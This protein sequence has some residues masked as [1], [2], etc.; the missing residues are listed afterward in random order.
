PRSARLLALLRFPACRPS[1]ATLLSAVSADRH[2]THP[3]PPSFP[4]RRSSDLELHLI[5]RVYEHQFFRITTLS[6]T[7]FAQGFTSCVRQRALIGHS[8]AQHIA[9]DSPS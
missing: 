5:L 1:A 8:N 2:R 3:H 7:S 9:F 6:V 4:T